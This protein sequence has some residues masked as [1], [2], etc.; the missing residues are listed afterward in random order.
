MTKAMSTEIATLAMARVGLP[1]EQI[2]C[3]AQ[4]DWHEQTDKA[5]QLVE[6]AEHHAGLQWSLA[7]RKQV[8]QAGSPGGH[9][10]AALVAAHLYLRLVV[11]LR[12]TSSAPIFSWDV[13]TNRAW[14]NPIGL[15]LQ[16]VALQLDQRRDELFPF[17]CAY[18][19]S[20]LIEAFLRHFW[21]PAADVSYRRLRAIDCEALQ[22]ALTACLAWTEDAMRRKKQKRLSNNARKA[23]ESVSAYLQTLPIGGPLSI[24][25]VELTPQPTFPDLYQGATPLVKQLFKTSG[26]ADQEDDEKL[27]Y[28]N[29]L[30]LYSAL[31]RRFLKLLR[32]D[33]KQALVGYSIKQEFKPGVGAYFNAFLFFDGDRWADFGI[34][35]DVVKQLWCA[36]MCANLTPAHEAAHFAGRWSFPAGR[37]CDWDNFVRQ[38]LAHQVDHATYLSLRLPADVRA[39]RRGT[40]RG[41]G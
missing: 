16:W 31:L 32:R 19:Q 14:P 25:R 24:V 34:L 27:L 29:V 20:P 28:R 26:I 18:E 4:S 9:V 37:S 35:R 13:A 40:N 11:N 8:F 1:V 5:R 41:E 21:Q 3:T 17:L 7:P 22:G 2:K 38:V 33:L 23:T 30:K 36:A 10:A 39:Y 15:R 12:R 6:Q